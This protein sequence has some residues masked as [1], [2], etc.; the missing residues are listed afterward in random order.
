MTI[1]K[2]IM[3]SVPLAFVLVL[4]AFA[5]TGADTDA[6]SAGATLRVVQKDALKNF[7]EAKEGV[8]SQRREALDK[9][10]DVRADLNEKK[11]EVRAE[12][13]DTKE[14][15]RA[16][17][18]EVKESGQQ[19][20]RENRDVAR[21]KLREIKETGD[22]EAFRAHREEAT[23]R[24][25]EKRDD[26]RSRFE[27]KKRETR[28]T[29]DAKRAELK[30]R[31]QNVR[32]EKKRGIMERL[33]NNVHKL[34]ERMLNHFSAVLEKLEGVLSRIGSRAD[35]AEVGGH[36]VSAV[37]T[38]IVEAENAI[39]A[40]RDAIHAQSGVVYEFDFNDE[41]G[42][43]SSAEQVRKAI[44]DDLT[45]VKELVRVAHDAVR[46]AAVALAQIPR[47]NDIEVEAVSANNS[48]SGVTLI[49]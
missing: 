18:K 37:L 2:K 1:I 21:D 32:D 44:H 4:P 25:R 20:L 40:A 43:R 38:A 35:K 13:R 39:A 23:D 7:R 26:F 28:E 30:E 46:R 15:V 24:L 36:D 45:R 6:R 47:V 27:E 10:R 41:T 31:L 9:V 29:L 33:E 49:E 17:L 14:G 42:L 22:V 12:F 5:Q 16:D 8:Q 48:D 3:F 11:I 19:E 34:N